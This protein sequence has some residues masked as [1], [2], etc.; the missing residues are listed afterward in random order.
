MKKILALIVVVITFFCVPNP[1]YAAMVESNFDTGGDGWGKVGGVRLSWR[2]SG[3]NPGGYLFFD[4]AG[5]DGYWANAPDS[6][7][8]NL[9]DYNNGYFSFDYRLIRVPPNAINPSAGLVRIFSGDEFVSL[10]FIS[11]SPPS[12]SWT[13]YTEALT[14]EA[15]GVA[16]D[17]WNA[18]LSDVTAIRIFMEPGGYPDESGLDNVVLATPL[19]ASFFLLC[20]GIIGFVGLRRKNI[21]L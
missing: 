3:G 2:S 1:V 15:W 12:Y 10:D 21:R 17:E 20:S 7:L 5:P 16:Q 4:D 11:Q 13:T 8:G 9:S 19:P 14:A 18:I 6:F